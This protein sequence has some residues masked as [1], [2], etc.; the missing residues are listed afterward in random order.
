MPSII[1]IINMPQPASDLYTPA[2]QNANY[3]S[4]SWWRI[5]PEERAECGDCAAREGHQ[6]AGYPCGTTPKRQ[7]VALHTD[8]KRTLVTED[9]WWTFH[10][11]R[12]DAAV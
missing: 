12:E 3:R 5:D 2:E 8:G 11:T 6:A 4:H 9:E 1:N 10:L 7:Y